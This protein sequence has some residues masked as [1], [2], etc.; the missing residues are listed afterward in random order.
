MTQSPPTC[1]YGTG[2]NNYPMS[3]YGYGSGAIQ[4]LGTAQA[5]NQDSNTI[6]STQSD[7]ITKAGATRK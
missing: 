4:P 6:S 2:W 7:N 3:N 5:N 1:Y